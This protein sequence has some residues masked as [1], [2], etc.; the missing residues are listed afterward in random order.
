MSNVSCALYMLTACTAITTVDSH[1]EAALDGLTLYSIS[2]F[3]KIEPLHLSTIHESSVKYSLFCDHVYVNT[4]CQFV[5]D[6]RIMLIT[7]TALWNIVFDTVQ[8]FKL[9]DKT[10]LAYISM[11]IT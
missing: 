10:Y 4:R 9:I 7:D 5:K 2:P 6:Y 1:T 11:Y 8:Y 3:L